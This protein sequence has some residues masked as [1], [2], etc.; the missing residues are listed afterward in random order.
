MAKTHKSLDEA[1]SSAVDEVLKDFKSSMKEAVNFAVVQGRVDFMN[2]ARSCL[3][4]YYDYFE[5]NIYERTENLQYAFLPYS[6]KL[7]CS[8][9][10]I[11]GTLGVEYSPEALAANMGNPEFY[12]NGKRKHTGYYGSEKH[13]PVD[14]TWVID[15]YLKGIH[16]ITNG[17]FTAESSIYAEVFDPISPNEKMEAFRDGYGE[18]FN[19]NVLVGLM[20]QIAKKIK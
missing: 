16:P 10:K 18:T 3:S 20:G 6:T 13:N 17:G 14:A 11:T 15:N 7:K 1:I 9:D 4:E 8:N 12:T 2:K 5:P 19:K